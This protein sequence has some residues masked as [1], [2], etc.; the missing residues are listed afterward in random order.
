MTGPF[1]KIGL[2][3]AFSPTAIKLLTETARLVGLFHS[4]LVLIHVGRHSED[5]YKRMDDLIIEAGLEPSGVKVV[6]EEG[7]PA[8]K[9]LKV[10]QQENLDLLIVGALKKERL[11]NLY[12][13]T[14]ARK[15]MR[16]ARCSVL[17]ICK[18]TVNP[19]PLSNI[20]V[21]A[22]DSH[23]ISDAIGSACWIGVRDKAH[24]V[25]IVRELKLLG[26][27]LSAA[28]QYTEEEYN[29]AK[30][31]LIQAEI[32]NVEEMLEGIP[33]DRVHINIKV[34]TGKSGFELARF[35]R[36]KKADLLVVGSPPRKFL[37]FDRVFPHDLE[38]IFAD[39]PCNLLIVQHIRKVTY[40]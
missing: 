26:L 20:V 14:I 34:V 30:Q 35:T 38:Y 19:K 8:V 17:V 16:K 40:D 36:R 13:G 5:A 39:L 25:H 9:I 28:N 6:W 37:W 3:V 11:L 1:S 24:W 27:T 10:S 32:D 22:E 12:I 7:D 29:Q 15:I 4:E 31:D 33:R 2:A 18:P 21:N 23:C